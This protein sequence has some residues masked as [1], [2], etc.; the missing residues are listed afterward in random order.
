MPL[1]EIEV[2]PIQ[3]I[4]GEMVLQEDLT[5]MKKTRKGDEPT[6]NKT[7]TCTADIFCDVRELKRVFVTGEAGHG[8][9]VFSLKLLK[10]W[11]NGKRTNLNRGQQS[12]SSPL[13]NTEDEARLIQC[14]SVYKLVFH[15][16]LRD[17]ESLP[18]GSSVVD[19]VCDNMPECDQNDK[20]KIKL[21]LGDRDIPC[22]IILDG[23][24]EY[25][26]PSVSRVKG[27]LERGLVNTVVLCT[28]RPWRMVN[29]ELK[30]DGDHDKVVQIC[31]LKEESIEQVFNSILHNF[32]GVPEDSVTYRN[33]KKKLY[34]HSRFPHVKSLIKIPLYLTL[35]CRVWYEEFK[36]DVTESDSGDDQSVES[37][38]FFIT[39]LY[40]KL[41]SLKFE[42]AEKKYDDVNEYVDEKLENPPTLQNTPDLLSEYFGSMIDFFEVIEPIGKLFFESLLKETRLVFPKRKLRRDIKP[43]ILD[44]ALQ[45]GIFSQTKSPCSSHEEMVSVNMH[46]SIREFIAALYVAC[47][48]E[49]AY[50]L[51]CE[52]CCTVDK[53]MKL[54]NM[55]MFVCGLDPVVGCRLSEHVK[56]VVNSDAVIT[57]YRE[58]RKLQYSKMGWK[59][60]QQGLKVLHKI[61]FKWYRE[62][63][64]N[65][66]YTQKT[67]PE[68]DLN[69]T[70]LHLDEDVDHEE[71]NMVKKLVSMEGNSIVSVYLDEM[72]IRSVHLRIVQNLPNCK[73]LT[74]LFIRD[75]PLESE[76]LQNVEM[77]A[78]VLPQLK[79]L[80]HVAY[81]YPVP[82][83]WEF[84]E[85]Y[86]SSKQMDAGD[87]FHGTYLT[88]SSIL[89]ISESFVTGNSHIH[90][91]MHDHLLIVSDVLRS[92]MQLPSLKCMEFDGLKIKGDSL[93]QDCIEQLETVVLHRVINVH[94]ILSPLS[95]C[96]QLKYIELAN[97]FFDD[98]VVLAGM[99]VLQTVVLRDVQNVHGFLPLLPKCPRLETLH[100]L[101]K[102]SEDVT[103]TCKV[104]CEVLPRL[105]NLQRIYYQGNG[106]ADVWHY[107]LDAVGILFQQLQQLRDI[108][109]ES[110]CL[111][112]ETNDDDK[113][114]QVVTHLQEDDD[115]PL[116]VGPL[117]LL[118]G[119]NEFGPVVKPHM[120]KLEN[121]GMFTVQMPAWR[122]LK[123]VSSL[124]NVK[125]PVHVELKYTDIDEDT[126]DM[127][128]NSE[129]YTIQPY[130]MVP[131]D[132][133]VYTP[134][135]TSFEYP[136]WSTSPFV[137]FETVPQVV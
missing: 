128:N 8:K 107:N 31:S 57:Q 95:H 10:V 99:P 22:L 53:V 47:K 76:Q 38:S 79:H 117:A 35:C 74:S 126:L 56:N 136:S 131:S 133:L 93:S 5:A 67:N 71:M 98:T 2:L 62:M 20:E 132:Y 61:H 84:Y 55:I 34:D 63:K 54:S 32:Y 29:L 27:F 3:A 124:L 26:L 15:V 49:S 108:M 44:F 86:F 83:W 101:L 121:V 96:R 18:E 51:F 59:V 105:D 104:L 89:F 28:M 129:S 115:D 116:A 88:L 90:K 30:L 92:A 16:P 23:L 114:G 73:N 127:V 25:K 80:K 13:Q 37:S 97:I 43:R 6:G 120:T 65:L 130:T 77:L 111:Q 123:F 103:K 69:A 87:L 9:T 14:L 41:F 112:D 7:L 1:N 42:R 119:D 58:G 125:Q 48:G 78:K 24:D 135:M 21:M 52:H 60:K 33:V 46:I 45:L 66:S 134:N 19:L 110:I 17:A 109:L 40:L 137:Q 39:C 64:N 72:K 122:W 75:S 118:F 100:L 94:F 91:I 68:L 36:G 82:M 11:A 85:R 106:S 70:D 4:Y 113:C 81:I 12:Q 50:K 102:S